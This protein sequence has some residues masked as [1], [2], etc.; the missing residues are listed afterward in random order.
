MAK[1]AATPTQ[2]LFVSETISEGLQEI[3]HFPGGH[4]HGR[5]APQALHVYYAVLLSGLWSTS[6]QLKLHALDLSTGARTLTYGF[7]AENSFLVYAF[8]CSGS[9]ESIADCNVVYFT[10]AT[11]CGHYWYSA[12]VQC[13]GMV[14]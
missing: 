9:E 1:L 7:T 3:Q 6:F 12:A 5:H 13:E 8:S 2:N 14:N 10:K 4:V 11:R